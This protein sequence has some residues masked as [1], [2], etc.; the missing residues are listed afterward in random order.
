[1]L[2]PSTERCEGDLSRNQRIARR[3]GEFLTSEKTSQLRLEH[4]RTVIRQP[5]WRVVIQFSEIV[6]EGPVMGF[7]YTLKGW[8]ITGYV[9][10]SRSQISHNGS[11]I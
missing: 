7:A 2:E 4:Q 8:L 3:V 6:G 10:L 9:Y 5:I 1:M 11:R